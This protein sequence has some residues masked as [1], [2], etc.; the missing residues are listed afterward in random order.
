MIIGINRPDG[1]AIEENDHPSLH[2]L[3]MDAA[4]EWGIEQA[5]AI[6]NGQRTL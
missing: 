3:D 1:S 4:K 5:K 2:I 6:G